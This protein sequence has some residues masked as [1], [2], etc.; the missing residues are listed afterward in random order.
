MLKSQAMLKGLVQLSNRIGSDPDLVQPGGGNTSVKLEEPD[1]FGRASRALAIK[2]SGTDLRTITE[3][4]FTHLDMD[5]LA[6]VRFASDDQMMSLM[7][8]AM[9]FPDRDP[10]P[11]VETPLHSLLPFTFV[12]HTHDV[13]TLSITDTTRPEELIRDCYGDEVVS[14]RRRNRRS[15]SRSML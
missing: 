4:G 11:S 10:L 15:L 13:A 2:G 12:V 6:L 14:L 1:C 3:A 8:A 7:R 5:R 9:L